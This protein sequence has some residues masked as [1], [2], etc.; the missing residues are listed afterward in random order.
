MKLEEI[1]TFKAST[2]FKKKLQ[3]L[4]DMDNRTISNYIK[5][6]IEKEFKKLK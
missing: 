1:I 6:L 4:A 5:T 3:K 2:E